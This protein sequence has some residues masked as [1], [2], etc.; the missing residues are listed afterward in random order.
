[1]TRVRSQPT[2]IDT[3]RLLL[4]V[5]ARAIDVLEAEMTE[6]F[7]LPLAWYEVL[8]FLSEAPDHQLRMHELAESRLLSRSAATR[9]IDRMEKAG[10]VCRTTC[11]EDRRG[12]FVQWTEAGRELFTRAGRL[13][14]EG[15]ER[16]FANVIDEEEAEVLA[17]VLQ[18][19]LAGLA[20]D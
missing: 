3:W 9:L 4:T 7:D 8:L 14:L 5:H 15:I 2:K 16:I 19:V 10:L 1:M 20:E 11:S 18:R 12:T 17:R 13:H 6:A